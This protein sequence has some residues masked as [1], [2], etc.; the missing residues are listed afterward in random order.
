MDFPGE[1]PAGVRVYEEEIKLRLTTKTLNTLR[2]V[3]AQNRTNVSAL[4]R[5]LIV[6]GIKRMEG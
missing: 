6:D 5:H 4:I 3:A 2:R 1:F